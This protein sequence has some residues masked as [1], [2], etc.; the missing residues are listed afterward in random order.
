MPEKKS[1]DVV[2][3]VDRYRDRPLTAEL[4]EWLETLVKDKGGGKGKGKGGNKG[5]GGGKDNASRG[6]HKRESPEPQRG[7]RDP[8]RRNQ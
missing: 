3:A 6:S 8:R 4:A 1:A 2:V 7:G 5:K